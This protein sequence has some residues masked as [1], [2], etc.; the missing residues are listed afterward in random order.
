MKI[1]LI[2]NEAVVGDLS[3][4]LRLVVQGY[5]QCLDRGAD[6]VVASAQALDGA[7]LHDLAARSSFRLQAC[8]AL[9]ALAGET[10]LPLLLASY[11]GLPDEPVQV[12]PYLL[13]QGKVRRLTNR[14]V[15]SICGLRLL[16]DAG[17]TPTPV[18]NKGADV[19][20]HLPGAPWWL[21][22]VEQWQK[23]ISHEAEKTSANVLLLRGIGCTEGQLAP[24]GSLAATPHGGRLNLPLFEPAARIWR[25]AAT[26]AAKVPPVGEQ[27]LKAICYGLKTSLEQGGYEGLAVAADATPHVPL[28]LGLARVAVGARRTVALC[29]QQTPACALAGKRCELTPA[30]ACERGLLM[31]SPHSLNQRLLGEPAAPLPAAS[32]APLGEV[33]ESELAQLQACLSSRLPVP[34]RKLLTPCRPAEHEESLRLLAEENASPAEISARYPGI[35]EATL[36]R[37]LRMWASAAPLLRTAPAPLSMRRHLVHL[38]VGHRL[39]E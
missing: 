15:V 4:N 1:G 8:A 29:K 38:P 22:Q 9:E 24:G 35:D 23:L 12:R 36:R 31:L 16:P 33:Y 25:A 20:L 17:D 26:A 28:L 13:C 30:Q 10:R 11:A 21:G 27:L 2:Q 39:H 37:Q 7:F 34:L 6:L 14:R 19:I 5:R 3:H 18:E 32:V